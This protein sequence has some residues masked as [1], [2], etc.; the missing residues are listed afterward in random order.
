M[1][2]LAP[3]SASDPS[4]HSIDDGYREGQYFMLTFLQDIILA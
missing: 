1:F 2:G 3:Q 4:A